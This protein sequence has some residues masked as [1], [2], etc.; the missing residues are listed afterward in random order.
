M[1]AMYAT[2][3]LDLYT[4]IVAFVKLAQKQ[5]ETIVLRHGVYAV[6]AT[7]LLGIMSL[8]LSQPITIDFPGYD[9]ERLAFYNMLKENGFK[10]TVYEGK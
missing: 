10:I 2:I 7:S 6:D 9:N 1:T 8:D 4:E 3:K 5:P